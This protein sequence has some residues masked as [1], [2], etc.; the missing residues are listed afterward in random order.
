MKQGEGIFLGTLDEDSGCAFIAAIGIIQDQ[1]PVTK[2]VWKRLSKTVLPNPQ[3]G[4]APWRERCFLFN[5]KR[6]EAYNFA[7][8][9]II[10]F[11]E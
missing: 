7:A 11:P 3:G 5:G 4:F 6:A 1:S 10:H 9:F 2:V 8:D